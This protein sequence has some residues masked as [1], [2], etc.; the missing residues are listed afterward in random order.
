MARSSQ[1]GA[2]IAQARL[3]YGQEAGAGTSNMAL[4]LIQR[5]LGTT[6]S[7]SVYSPTSSSNDIFR[8]PD[9]HALVGKLVT[10]SLSMKL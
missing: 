1:K 5:H 6:G 9:T 7:N 8:Y 4:T 3:L 10:T 2:R